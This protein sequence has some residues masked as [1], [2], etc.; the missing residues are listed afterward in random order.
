[1]LA[2]SLIAWADPVVTRES[3]DRDPGWEGHN[4]VP[5]PDVGMEKTQDFRF[6]TTNHAGSEAGEIRGI[7][8]RIE[9]SRADNLLWYGTPVDPLR[10]G[11][12]LRAPGKVS[13][14]LASAGTTAGRPSVRRRP[15]SLA[16]LAKARAGLATTFGPRSQTRRTLTYDPDANDGRGRIVATLDGQDA[17]MH[18]PPRARPAKPPSTTSVC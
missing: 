12:A 5:P 9:N 3:F 8:W 1:L 15:T 11:K 4:N 18:L 17:V 14:E 2:V 16:C 13:M 7:V 10:L 6:Q